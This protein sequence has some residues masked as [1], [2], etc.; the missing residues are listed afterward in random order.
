MSDETE[1]GT[2]PE[3]RGT[4]R[5]RT[6]RR[7]RQ[8]SP[9]RQWSDN[10]P[11][12]NCLFFLLDDIVGF[13]FYNFSI[14]SD[15]LNRGH[16]T[17]LNSQPFKN[18]LTN[19]VIRGNEIRVRGL[20]SASGNQTENNNLAYNRGYNLHQSIMRNRSLRS[21]LGNTLIPLPIR[22]ENLVHGSL[23]IEK[24]IRTM[25]VLNP[26]TYEDTG[27][28]QYDE[29]LS[30]AL[31]RSAVI[32]VRNP[33]GQ[34]NYL[35]F[36]EVSQIAKDYL[37]RRF[38]RS[39]PDY[40]TLWIP[41]RQLF[42]KIIPTPDPRPSHSGRGSHPPPT[43]FHCQGGINAGVRALRSFY[44]DAEFYYLKGMITDFYCSSREIED[45]IDYE[46]SN[47]KKI[48]YYAYRGQNSLYNQS[49]A[50]Y[51]SSGFNDLQPLYAFRRLLSCLRNDPYGLLHYL[52]S[53]PL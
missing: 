15:T 41:A 17:C 21:I 13:L 26:V 6:R 4:D 3:D 22:E 1:R 7:P 28:I 49:L 25:H 43:D 48:I 5:S 16:I 42:H 34:G 8:V 29:G 19:A 39:I 27:R 23:H 9:E 45:R 31:D 35:P 30:I 11:R 52:D 38:N 33:C 36:P 20:A 24:F 14:S 10:N 46:I 44:P 37:E 51:T 40:D 2:R 50:A 12:G 47:L 32:Y 53:D 18:W